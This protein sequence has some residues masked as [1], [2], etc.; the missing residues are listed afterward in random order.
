MGLPMHS[1]ECA[2]LALKPL[3]KQEKLH[4]TIPACSQLYLSL[5]RKPVDLLGFVYA[6]ATIR[7]LITIADM[8]HEQQEPSGVLGL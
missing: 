1:R 3:D 7:V 8:N 5:R 6:N 4:L 2:T